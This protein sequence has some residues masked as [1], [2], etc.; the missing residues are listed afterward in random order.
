MTVSDPTGT[1]PAPGWYD[2]PFQQVAGQQR[3]WSGEAWTDFVE[4][5]PEAAAMPVPT[6][7]PV[8]APAVAPAGLFGQPQPFDFGA[9]DRVPSAAPAADIP[10]PGAYG[11]GDEGYQPMSSARRSVP[12]VYKN[13]PSRWGT[14]SVWMIALLPI[15][16]ILAVVLVA[17]VMFASGFNPLAIIGA[18]L[19]PP[20]LVIA[21]VIR[22]RAR[23]DS[24][25]YDAIP[26]GW[27]IL[28]GP[29]A[30]LIARYVVTRREANKGAAPLVTYI[31]VWLAL[32][33]ASAVLT[34]AAPAFVGGIVSDEAERSI[35]AELDGT[36]GGRHTVICP[37]SIPITPGSVTCEAI[38]DQGLVATITI[39]ITASG[40]FSWNTPE[41]V[42]PTVPGDE[43][44]DGQ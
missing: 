24:F 37:P 15:L 20:L 8:L 43:T 1:L 29:I 3:W 40:D 4:A 39:V 26:S 31:V 32:T 14:V 18:L 22:D 10:V 13:I 27:W 33:V 12:V 23:L 7:A 11:G 2:D 42:A 35:A 21:W 5:P 44:T 9:L 28:L 16:Q 30:Y 34:F 41:F 38:N 6:P 36:L 19:V 25:G 17:V